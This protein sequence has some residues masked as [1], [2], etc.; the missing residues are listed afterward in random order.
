MRFDIPGKLIVVGLL[1]NMA[2]SEKK[3]K[4]SFKCARRCGMTV[5]R[6]RRPP[7]FPFNLIFHSDTRFKFL[8]RDV[9][10]FLPLAVHC[11]KPTGDSPESL[12]NPATTP[13]N[14]SNLVLVDGLLALF[15]GENQ[16]KVTLS[17]NYRNY[18]SQNFVDL[19]YQKTVRFLT[20]RQFYR[21]SM[22]VELKFVNVETSYKNWRIKPYL[23]FLQSYSSKG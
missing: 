4:G 22:T 6:S 5:T 19:S 20:I 18:R 21:L 9:P 23:S 1:V 2:R 14:L 17:W 3:T 15:N 16:L 11:S 10:F 13:N 12:F 8:I 7:T